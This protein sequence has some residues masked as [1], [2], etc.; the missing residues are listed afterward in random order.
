MIQLKNDTV[1]FLN[2]A[3]FCRFLRIDSM[4]GWGVGA[5]LGELLVFLLLDV[6]ATFLFNYINLQI[7]HKIVRFWDFYYFWNPLLGKSRA[8]KPPFFSF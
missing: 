3:Y 7:I 4:S 1:Y 5:M 2:L 6:L 8:L